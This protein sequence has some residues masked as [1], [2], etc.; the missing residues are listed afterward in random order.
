MDIFKVL[1]NKFV[2]NNF[3]VCADGFQCPSK[4]FTKPYTIINFFEITYL[5]KIAA[6]GSLKRVTGRIYR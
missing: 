6:L 3:C 2:I 4:L 5:K 1:K